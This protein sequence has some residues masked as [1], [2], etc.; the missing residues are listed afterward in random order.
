MTCKS[1]IT[2]LLLEVSG[3]EDTAETNIYFGLVLP[4]GLGVE[5]INFEDIS[6]HCNALR[7]VPFFLM[8][9]LQI[10]PYL[11]DR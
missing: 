5:F 3:V 8:K 2:H 7:S 9:Q 11:L 4:I 10:K 6:P 1:E